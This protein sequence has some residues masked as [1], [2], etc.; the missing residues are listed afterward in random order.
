MSSGSSL[1]FQRLSREPLRPILGVKVGG[2]AFSG[3]TLRCKK[4][5]T[6]C[7]A[8]G[9]ATENMKMVGSKELR[10]RWRRQRVKLSG[11]VAPQASPGL[12]TVL[13]RTHSTHRHSGQ[14][15]AW[16]STLGLV[17]YLMGLTT[18]GLI[19]Q[20]QI[21]GKCTNSAA[22]ATKLNGTESNTQ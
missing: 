10:R 2:N 17:P 4:N 8:A 21:A 13:Q 19:S 5:W 14:G 7:G 1:A 6:W 12:A 22:D 20:S 9:A 15:P 16:H 3:R 18:S 11:N